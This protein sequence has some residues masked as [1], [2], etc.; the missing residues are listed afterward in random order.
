MFDHGAATYV[1]HAT[2]A[3]LH[4]VTATV[5]SIS[6]SRASRLCG[7]GLG[8]AI[9]AAVISERGL[10]HYPTADDRRA[11]ADLASRQ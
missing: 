5:H 1:D 6:E 2:A 9:A 11:G 8:G 4:V 7:A 10:D 3:P